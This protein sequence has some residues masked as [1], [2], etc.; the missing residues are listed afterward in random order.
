MSVTT[1]QQLSTSSPQLSTSSPYG[2]VAVYDNQTV[3]EKAGFNHQAVVQFLQPNGDQ[4]GRLAD[5]NKYALQASMS[6]LDGDAFDF[7]GHQHDVR[8]ELSEKIQELRSHTEEIAKLIVEIEGCRGNGQN[9]LIQECYQELVAGANEVKQIFEDQKRFFTNELKN[10]KANSSGSLT[11]TESATRSLWVHGLFAAFS[12]FCGVTTLYDLLADHNS[13]KKGPVWCCIMREWL[14]KVVSTK[15]PNHTPKALLFYPFFPFGCMSFSL[16]NVYHVLQAY[17]NRSIVSRI[18]VQTVK[19]TEFVRANEDMWKGMEQRV[20]Q[21]LRKVQ[22]FNGLNKC[23]ETAVTTTLREIGHLL[24]E[25]RMSVDVYMVWMEKHKLF[26]PNV[27]IA[28]IIGQSAYSAIKEI[29]QS[30]RG[31]LSRF[32]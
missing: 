31:F 20:D 16:W 13:M 25:M 24:F 21:L 30:R 32:R 3:W 18:K 7:T 1:I 8:G 15:N 29:I 2:Q 22:Y 26:P 19:D 27:A 11:S 4:F 6:I 10:Q 9:D 23:R 28:S 5:V 14:A 12:G 17:R